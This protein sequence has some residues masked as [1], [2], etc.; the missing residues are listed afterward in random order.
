M[1]VGNAEIAIS[2]DCATIFETDLRI[3]CK[4]FTCKKYFRHFFNK[5]N[6]RINF[7]RKK[8][9]C[10]IFPVYS[11]PHPLV[12]CLPINHRA[13]QGQNVWRIHHQLQIQKTINDFGCTQGKVPLHLPNINTVRLPMNGRTNGLSYLLSERRN[14][15][16]IELLAI[17]YCVISLQMDGWAVALLREKRDRSLDH[18]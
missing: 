6:H 18:S 16:A 4:T 3:W 14:H 13:F 5:T 1:N 15:S 7:S 10:L 17:L 2:G 8:L 12:L 9:W 11:F